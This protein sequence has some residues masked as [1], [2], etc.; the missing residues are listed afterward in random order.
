MGDDQVISMT[1]G[2]RVRLTGVAA[3][4]LVA[5]VAPLVHTGAAEGAKT[6]GPAAY[7][8]QLTAQVQDA[9]GAPR[10]GSDPARQQQASLATVAGRR[11]GPGLRTSTPA[12]GVRTGRI[13]RQ[14]PPAKTA[15]VTAGGCAV[16][17]GQPGVQCLPAHGP[18]STTLTCAYVQT[19]FPAGLAVT[20]VDRLHLDTDRDGVACGPGDAGVPPPAPGSSSHRHGD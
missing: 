14:A 4:V 6:D 16:G 1:P 15:G 17:Y 20:G 18:D 11:Q 19:I 10:A 7:Q 9:V 3:A 8:R 2:R 5:V 13:V 12:A